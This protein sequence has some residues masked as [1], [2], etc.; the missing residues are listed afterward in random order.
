MLLCEEGRQPYEQHVTGT[1]DMHTD[2]SA[3]LTKKR[4]PYIHSMT[5]VPQQQKTSPRKEKRTLLFSFLPSSHPP[6]ERWF[7]DQLPDDVRQSFI[8]KNDD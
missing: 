5:C 6:L 7:Q 4:L 2:L 1:T 3:F 8:H